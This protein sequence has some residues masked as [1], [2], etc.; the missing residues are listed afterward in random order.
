MGLHLKSVHGKSN[1]TK[2]NPLFSPKLWFMISFS[3]V[4]QYK[5]ESSLDVVN[6]SMM[7]CSKCFL[8]LWLNTNYK[9]DCENSDHRN[10]LF[11]NTE[12]FWNGHSLWTFMINVSYIR[13]LIVLHTSPHAVAR[14][15]LWYECGQQGKVGT[16]Q[17]AEWKC[18]SYSLPVGLVL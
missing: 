4:I 10:K 12:G 6:V 3:E 17:W 9:K 8:V 13:C 15:S 14:W 1:S 2:K 16:S 7:Y 11:M 18:P 5:G